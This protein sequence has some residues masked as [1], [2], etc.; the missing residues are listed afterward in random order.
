MEQ[1]SSQDKKKLFMSM[2]ERAKNGTLDMMRMTESKEYDG[3]Y[4]KLENNYGPFGLV[5]GGITKDG[6][7]SVYLAEQLSKQ[8]PSNMVGGSMISSLEFEEA[9]LNDFLDRFFDMNNME[10]LNEFYKN[11]P[12]YV[13][14]ASLQEYKDEAYSD[15]YDRL[16]MLNALDYFNQPGNFHVKTIGRDDYE[17]EVGLRVMS[18]EEDGNYR[19]VFGE[20]KD[21]VTY[22]VRTGEIKE[23]DFENPE[24][25][26]FFNKFLQSVED[27]PKIYEAITKGT[28]RRENFIPTIDAHKKQS[29]LQQ[30]ESELA[31][32]EAEEK[33]ISEA[34]ALID[35]QTEKEGR[36][37][38]E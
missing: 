8:L 3:I 4:R 34:E 17:C 24:F 37:I 9:E 27:L 25:E 36:N 2:V 33:T 35:K 6:K 7:V 21:A 22:D 18:F 29:P 31:S 10:I 16:V 5:V 26:K 23:K 14:N 28:Y 19:I 32:L 38:G 11:Q 12:D 13:K 15:F 20:G 1:L 30:R